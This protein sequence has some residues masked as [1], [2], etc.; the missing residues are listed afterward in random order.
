VATPDATKP[1]YD[2]FKAAGTPEQTA[3][4]AFALPLIGIQNW[5]EVVDLAR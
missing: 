4:F 5:S 1:I 3:A 2:C